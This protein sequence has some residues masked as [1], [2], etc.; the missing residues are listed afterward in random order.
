MPQINDSLCKKNI[1]LTLINYT[2]TVGLDVLR[3]DIDIFERLAFVVELQVKTKNAEI[4][5]ST[6]F[7]TQLINL[8]YF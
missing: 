3:K 5:F 2:F 7:F 8:A 1:Q 6:T 4:I